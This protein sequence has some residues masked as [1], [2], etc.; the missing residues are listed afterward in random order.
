MMT[1]I[2]AILIFIINTS[3]AT[4]YNTTLV[5]DNEAFEIGEI[6]IGESKGV[7]IFQR[8]SIQVIFTLG[9][10]REGWLGTDK[11]AICDTLVISDDIETFEIFIEK[12][13]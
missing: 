12:S 1:K 4:L 2:L 6:E 10:E 3:S 5:V 8:D 13:L 11:I 7:E 9:Q